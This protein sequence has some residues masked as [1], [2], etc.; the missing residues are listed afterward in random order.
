MFALASLLGGLGLFLL[1][2]SMMTDG[3]K[4]AAGEALRSILA[5]W[6]GTPLRGLVAGGLVTALVQSSSAVTVAIIGFVNAGLLNLKQAVFVIFGANVGTTMTG[7]LVALVGIKIDVGSFALP[8]LGI[9]MLVRLVAGSQARFAGIGRALAGFGAFF[10]GVGVLQQGF[11]ELA[12]RIAGLDLG[13]TGGLAI[14]TFAGLGTLLTVLTQSS[15][16]AIAI[17][18]TASAG[19]EVPL[20]AAAAAVIG[21]NIGTT[22]TALFAAIGATSPA[23]RVASAHIAFN[24]LS[25]IVALALLPFLVGVS[26]GIANRLGLGEGVPTTLAVFHTL[27]NLLGIVVI[28]PLTP[29][30]IARLSRLYVS[31]EEEI[32]R[33]RYLDANLAEVPTLA[34]DGLVRESKRMRDATF[35]LARQRVMQ[36]AGRHDILAARQGGIIRLGEAIREFIDGLG[37]HPVPEAVSKVLPNIVRSIQHLET[38][39]ITSERMIEAP[40]PAEMIA[41]EDW[42][43]F[44]SIVLASLAETDSDEELP[45]RLNLLAERSEATYQR[46]KLNLLTEIAT[47]RLHVR[48]VD[49]A[50]L[51]AQRLR[52]IADSAVKARRRVGQV[53][54]N[55]DGE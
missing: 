29:W 45:D 6:T 30:L 23:K 55:I 8:L 41:S 51:Y 52:R 54:H 11:A 2:M 32:G 24:L 12:P 5:R 3:L 9:G 4:M 39:V 15:S 19:G 42:A 26:G 35:A 17:I 28:W 16:A 18:L 27:F 31:S 38:I 25:S 36:P 13:V 37:S 47:G 44:R 53:E 10:L 34:V 48:S 22:S 33:P 7:W 21:T 50:L 43:E 49:A 40:P 20:L 46:L 1:G 14:A